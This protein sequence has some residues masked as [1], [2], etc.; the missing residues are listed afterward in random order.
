M[1]RYIVELLRFAIVVGL[2]LSFMIAIL[3]QA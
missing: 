1:N 2:A 3:L